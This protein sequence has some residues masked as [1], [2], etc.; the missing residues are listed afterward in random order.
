MKRFPFTSKWFANLIVLPILLKLENVKCEIVGTLRFLLLDGDVDR[1]SKTLPLIFVQDL[2][3]NLYVRGVITNMQLRDDQ[4]VRITFGKP[5]DKKGNPASVQEGSVSISVTDGSATVEPDP[6]DPFSATIIGV[7]PTADITKPGAVIITA[8]ADLGEGVKNI[9]GSE[10]LIV[11]GG[12][13]VGFGPAS[14]G[15]AE[16]Q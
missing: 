16:D 3:T 10:P 6:A 2:D 12:Q 5:L 15:T 8:D 13:A 11:T 9:T 1:R 7:S 14:V 4:K